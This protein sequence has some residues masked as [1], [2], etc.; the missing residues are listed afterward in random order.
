MAVHS[1]RAVQK[2]PADIDTVWELFSRAANLSR[3]TPPELSFRIRSR[4]HGEGIYCG[5]IIEYSVKPLFGIPVYWMTEITHV[6]KHRSFIDV[7]RKGPYAFWH[8]QHHFR[9]I[10]GGVE[11]TDI[12]HYR[13]PLG[14]A[15][16][17]V[18]RLLVR[19]KLEKIFRFRYESV[20]GLFG[21]WENGQPVI[22]LS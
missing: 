9:E 7:Q 22:E 1:L 21:S 15:G 12:V 17:I 2:I 16:R 6:E 3:I 13:L 11:M 8:H 5:Q 4:H 19:K 20:A 18:N 14:W 10:E